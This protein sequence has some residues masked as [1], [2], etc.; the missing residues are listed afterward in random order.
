M[1]YQIDK[2]NGEPLVVVEDQTI[3]T[4]ATDLRL[5]GRNYAGYGEIQNE[6][7]VHLLENFSN[8]SPPPR[9]L[10]GQ[11]WYDSATQKLKFYDGV[12]FR[13]AGG[14][15]VSALPPVGLSVGDF[16]FNTVEQQLF[17]WTG[18]QFLLVGP[19]KAPELGDT[20]AISEV[21][22]DLS[23][24]DRSILKL[25]VGGEIIAIISKDEFR[26]NS[27]TNPITGF[28]KINKGITL[29]NLSV[30]DEFSTTTTDQRFWG[31]ASN[32][33]RLNGFTSED[34][35]RSNNPLFQTQAKF[36]DGGLVVGDQNDLRIRVINGNEP[37]IENQLNGNILFRISNSGANI[38]DVAIIQGDGLVPG[39][40]DLFLLGKPGI[41]WKEVNAETI[42][43]A[44]FYGKL[45][46][47]IEPPPP[48]PGQPNPPL[49]FQAVN[50]SG[51]LSI[52]PT[53]TDPVSFI[54]DLES[55]PGVIRLRSGQP[56]YIDNVE[57][58]PF[59]PR[60][61]KFTELSASNL[62]SFTDTTQSTSPTTGALKVAGG[63]GIAKNLNVGGDGAF[64]GTGALRIPTGSTSQ[65]PSNPV[66]GM[67]RF[68]IDIEDVEVF[69]GSD[70]RVIGN[71]AQDD[72]GDLTPSGVSLDYRFV[73][74]S[75]DSQVDYG[76]L[77]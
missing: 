22:K 70:W 32:S 64:D 50:I 48:P 35:V 19:E 29:I 62:V 38:R 1:P 69:D 73:N 28:S 49:E 39:R 61:G 51:N 8:T 30:S 58:N 52:A 6:N 7:I 59:T 42:N 10:T 27:N 14:A 11:I 3:N 75:V 68:N 26:L 76:P 25:I 33:D 67:I 18:D 34:F 21:V 13:V 17:T 16:W 9:P 20:I 15:E 71:I 45:V 56:G 54:V 37:L 72:Y 40:N 65:R 77:F 66:R 2:Y 47:T 57:I 53:G 36:K 44:T 55:N 4:T 5:V 46:G 60:L 63:T 31:T 74:E 23:N 12:D 41:R 43:A 24:T